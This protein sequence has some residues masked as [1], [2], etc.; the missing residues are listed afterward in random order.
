M[1][2]SW[3][4]IHG[5]SGTAVCTNSCA[6]FT[7]CPSLTHTLFSWP[8]LWLSSGES[9]TDK[10]SGFVSNKRNHWCFRPRLC[11][12]RLYWAETTWANEMNFLLDHAPGAGSIARPVDKQSNTLPLSYGR[13]LLVLRDYES[14]MDGV[15]GH[16]SALQ[17]TGMGKTWTNEVNFG[18]N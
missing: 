13:P 5:P 1:T 17:D 16:E 10:I 11:I 12:V 8:S 18:V 2:L 7:K 14:W 3:A 4:S 9:S 6:R 15:S